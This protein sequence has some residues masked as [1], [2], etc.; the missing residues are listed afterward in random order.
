[1]SG[2]HTSEVSCPFFAC[3]ICHVR[4]LYVG[5]VMFGFCMPEV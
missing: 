5:G 4:L 2:I 1:M 3:R